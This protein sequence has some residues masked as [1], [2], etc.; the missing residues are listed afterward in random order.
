MSFIFGGLFVELIGDGAVE[1]VDANV[2]ED[3]FIEGLVYL[4]LG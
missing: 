1:L 3:Y 4:F 2:C